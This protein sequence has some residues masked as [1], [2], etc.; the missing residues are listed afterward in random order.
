ML[1]CFRCLFSWPGYKS[2]KKFHLFLINSVLFACLFNV[3][4]ASEIEEREQ[5][6]KE[7]LFIAEVAQPKILKIGLVDCIT[8]ALKNNAEIKIEKIEPLI[9]KED[10][11][12]AKSTFEPTLSFEGSLED[13][14]I[15][16]PSRL[17]GTH[18]RTG[19]FNVGIDGKLSP[20]TEYGIGFLNKKYKSNSAYLSVNP[21]YE[22]EFAITI[23]QPLFKDFGTIVNRADIIIANNDMAKSNQNLKKEII[24]I[25]SEVKEVYYNYVLNIEKYKTAQISLQRAKDLLDILQKRQAKGMASSID[26]LEAKTG[27]AEREDGLLSIKQAIEGAEDNLKYV[28][29]L[30]NDPQL[31]HAQI[32][33]LDK[34]EL[35][36]DPVDLVESLQ[37]AFE[38]RPDYQA[39]KIELKNQNIRIQV[40]E[41][42]ALPT[43]D[44]VGSLGLN[45]LDK[46]YNGALKA[47][48]KKWSTG[49]KISFPWGNKAALADYEQA[50]LTKKQLLISF[51]RL[52]QNIILEVRDAVRGVNIAQQKIATAK[53]RVDTETARYQAI[54]RRFQEGLVSAHDM[55][56]YQEDLSNA[57]TGF[58]QSLIDYSTSIVNLEK[59]M[60]VTLVRSNIKMEE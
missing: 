49:V 52:Q 36:E 22:S 56:E 18:T 1:L 16:S 35:K 6:V 10:I 58:I 15:E 11:K 45:G 38:S 21:Y 9:S 39:S 5:A 43:I 53:E 60:G 54:E 13:D 4:W 25:I 46:D 26:I 51:E 41:N 14:K 42:A 44:L 17:A 34:P 37:Q 8:Y 57:E 50:Y 30:V 24:N 27:V 59:M 33:P 31:W 48:Y 32:E 29:G 12:I 47:D 40:K 7:A 28:T 3:V 23:T 2:M 55:L 19:E 20:G